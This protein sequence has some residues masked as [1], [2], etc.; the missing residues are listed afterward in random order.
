MTGESR[1]R[2]RVRSITYLGEMINAYEVV[3]PD[4]SELPPF[5]AGA[6]IDLYFRDGRIR[7]YSLAN[8][9]AE[10]HRYVFA[11]QSE[12]G[13]RGGSV[14]VFEKVHV[15]RILTISDPRNNFPLEESASRHL[16]VAGGIGVTP[17]MSMLHRLQSI[18]A[19]FEL[20]YCARSPEKA[21]FREELAAYL[22]A[23]S[24]I[25]HYD[26]GDP[27]QGL[28]L[29][30]LLAKREE[31]TH[32]YFC[33]PTGFMRGVQAAA[34]H[35]PKGT[36]HCEFFTPLEEGLNSAVSATDD[37]IAV[38]FQVKIASTGAI[39][40]VPNDKSIVQVLR[41]QGME[42]E[43]SCES[44]LCG[45]CRTRFLEGKPEHHDYILDD[46][47]QEEFVMICSAR[48]KTP[49]LVLDL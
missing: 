22:S 44:G 18:G 7:Q 24:A 5:E 1:R 48:S 36:V 15:G 26:G 40:D 12:E 6:H 21:A 9:P 43:T 35:W 49:L 14:A 39:Y 29:E 37:A 3:D 38:G 10:R 33:G 19:P 28:D 30:A 34:A 27:K 31:G 8:D 32:L 16:L 13:G 2:V 20:H 47:E 11:V 45:T 23:G 17:I 41:A 25:I 42:V 4:G 46:D